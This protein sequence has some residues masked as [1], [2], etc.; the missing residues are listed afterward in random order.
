MAGVFLGSEAVARGTLTRGQLRWNYR[1]IHRDV[2]LPKNVPRSLV[3]N[4]YA[5]W[6]WSGRR[7]IIAGR[8]AAALHGAKW[9][10]NFAPIEIVGPFNHPPGGIIVRRERIGVEDLVELS[11]LLVTNPART[12]FDLARHLPRG[13]AVAHLDALSAATGLTAAALA[14]L[15]DRHKGARGVRRCQ[16]ALSLMDGGAQSPKES[17]LRLALIDAGLPRPVTQIRVTDG[18]LLAYLDMGWEEPMVALEYDGDQHRS[19]RRQYVKDIRRAEMVD[20]LGWHVIKV[21]NEDRPNVVIE[22]ARDALGRCSAPRLP[23]RLP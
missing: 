4:I 1:Q 12:A 23:S 10:D 2:Y 22:R 18:H 15:L 6:L 16:P 14:P 21:I 13:V 3:D 11:G 19:D 9:M 17:W 8:A 7:G 5:A 20:R